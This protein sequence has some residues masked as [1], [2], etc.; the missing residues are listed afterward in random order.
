MVLKG[1]NSEILHTW[2]VKFGKQIFSP[3]NYDVVL[4]VVCN[5][6]PWSLTL[7][8]ETNCQNLNFLNF[9]PIL[10]HYFYFLAEWSS[11]VIDDSIK[12]MIYFL[13][14]EKGLK[15]QNFIYFR[16]YANL[17]FQSFDCDKGTSE[18]PPSVMFFFEVNLFAVK[19]VEEAVLVDLLQLYPTSLFFCMFL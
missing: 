18:F 3:S 17:Y 10:M 1:P 4:V 7:L 12:K 8:E 15:F 11:W 19:L 14:V 5:R 2:K 13:S 6:V 9:N 16:R